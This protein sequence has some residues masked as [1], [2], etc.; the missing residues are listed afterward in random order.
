MR[1]GKAAWPVNAGSITCDRETMRCIDTTAFV[2]GGLLSSDTTIREIDRW[3]QHEIV[4][5]PNDSLCV[6]STIRLSREQRT[7]LETQNTFRA[8]GP[9]RGLTIGEQH[10]SLEDGVQVANQLRAE[11]TI[12]Q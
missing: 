3:D 11:A 9:C 7:V 10:F 5:K 12:K 8:D 4:T 1:E 6:R 2:F